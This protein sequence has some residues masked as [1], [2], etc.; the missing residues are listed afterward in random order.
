LL[1]VEV[2]LTILNLDVGWFVGAS[3]LGHDAYRIL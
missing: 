2:V 3:K 1:I